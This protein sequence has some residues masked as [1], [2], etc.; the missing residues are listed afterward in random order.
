MKVL[1]EAALTAAQQEV[2]NSACT[3]QVPKSYEVRMLALRLPSEV[4]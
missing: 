1:K 3:E 2:L 4:M